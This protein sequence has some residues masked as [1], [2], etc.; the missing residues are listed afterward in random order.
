MINTRDAT[1]V[2]TRTSKA[3]NGVITLA[4][5]EKLDRDINVM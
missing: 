1:C 3:P 4:A 5:L 2:A